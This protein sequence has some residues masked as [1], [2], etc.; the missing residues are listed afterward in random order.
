MSSPVIPPRARRSLAGPI[1]LI[2][3][4]ALFLL[5]SMGVLRGI[6]L[7]HL[8]GR[9]W[10]VLIILWGVVKLIEYH[11]AQ[12]EGSR[13]RGIGAGGVFLLILLIVF[14]LAATE[15]SNVNW[16]ALRDEINIDDEDFNP[17]VH[18]YNFD[19]ELSQ[20][21]PAGGSLH[22]VDEHGAVNVNVSAG[23]QIKVVVRKRVGADDQQSANNYNAQTKP[24][25]RVSGNVVTLNANTRGAGEHSVITDMDVYVPRKAPVSISSRRGEVNVN[26]RDGDVEISNQRGQVSLEDLNGNA[27]LSLERS[28]ARAERVAGNVS[29]EGRA[30]DVEVK[31]VQGAVRLNG[32]FMESVKL[33]KIANGVTFKSSRTDM[34]FSKLDG[35]L[36]LDSGD[37][38]ANSVNGPLRLLTRSKDIRIDQVSGDVRVED[39]NGSIELQLR[40]PGNVQI[41]NRKGDVQIALPAKAGF[42]VDARARGGEIESDFG[43][44]KVENAN[45]QATAKG[46]IGNGGPHLLITN[47]HGTIEIHKGATI[48]ATPPTPPIPPSPRPPRTLSAPK[49]ERPE[50]N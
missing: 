7:W 18:T 10:P 43:E 42:Q 44:L 33:S 31:D 35:E 48:A 39:E 17:F 4:G 30:N 28:S 40:S 38:H 8:F 21:F 3:V 49:A 13:P 27:K 36:D 1:V 15:T 5:R 20:S 25:I 26:G 2:T 6:H 16:G 34:E 37:L 41:Q 9:F 29:V 47:E 50:E 12:S 46:T 14:G 45:G 24:Q 23:E 11:E 19:D 22:V 32:E